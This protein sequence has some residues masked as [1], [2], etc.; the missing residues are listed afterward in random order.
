MTMRAL[1]HKIPPPVV[2]LL[3]GVAMWAVARR[4]VA[5]PIHPGLRRVL[6]GS[7]VVLGGVI[8]ALGVAAFRRAQTTSNPMKPETAAALVTSGVYRF[9]RNPMYL[10]GTLLLLGWAAHLAVPWGILGPV[11][12]VAWI[13]R[14]QI[15]PEERALRS[16]FGREYAEYQLRVG[17]WLSI[18][19][20]CPPGRRRPR[21]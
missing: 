5:L 19:C 18:P 17:R 8:N 7:L 13:T 10:G 11:V 12:F 2:A 21:T 14:L 15:L 16:K 6:A 20:R 4:T 3:L 1:E 9:T